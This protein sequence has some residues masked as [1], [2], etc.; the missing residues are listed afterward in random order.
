MAVVATWNIY[1]KI[2]CSPHVKH[3]YWQNIAWEKYVQTRSNTRTFLQCEL[4]FTMHSKMLPQDFMV[5]VTIPYF[6]GQVVLHDRLVRT[7]VHMPVDEVNHARNYILWYFTSGPQRL[8]KITQVDVCRITLYD[9]GSVQ[10]WAVWKWYNMKE[11]CLLSKKM[12]EVKRKR[13]M[14]RKYKKRR[15]MVKKEQSKMRDY[16]VWSFTLSAPSCACCWT[17]HFQNAWQYRTA[18]FVP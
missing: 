12:K 10:T 11:S 13:I 9:F 17:S 5:E 8:G 16:G 18:G 1:H 3:S 6:A 15:W 14:Y 4:E 7:N 2:V